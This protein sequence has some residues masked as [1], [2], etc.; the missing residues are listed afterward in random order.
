VAGS[1]TRHDHL[2]TTSRSRTGDVAFFS[3]CRPPR[4]LRRPRRSRTPV[5]LVLRIECKS[6][7]CS[8]HLLSSIG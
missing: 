6:L 4:H 5:A 7:L 3:P 2:N 1:G 8:P